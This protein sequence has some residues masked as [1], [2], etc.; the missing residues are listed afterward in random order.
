MEARS[1]TIESRFRGPPRSGNGGYVCGRLAALIDGPARVRLRVPPPLDRPLVGRR[2]GE[3]ARLLDGDEVVATAIPGRPQLEVPRPPTL[4]QA[5][6]ARER[7]AGQT[8][9]VFPTCFVCGP[10]RE[11][12]DALCIYAGPVGDGIV[13][14]PFEVPPDLVDEGGHALPEIVWAALDCPG[15][16]AVTGERL[17][18]M[19]LGELC[20]ELRA[21]VPVGETLVAFAWPLQVEGRKAHCGS[22][23]ATR[24]G[25]VLAVGRGTW[26][27]LTPEQAAKAMGGEGP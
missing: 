16:F 11:P 18:P 17:Q 4:E 20:A 22:A 15:Y 1:I 2:E 9:H 6:R 23:V 27:R 13:A 8:G 26:I 19:V 10:Q 7:Y 5:R 14:A 12:G 3:E 24:E 21:A 25:E